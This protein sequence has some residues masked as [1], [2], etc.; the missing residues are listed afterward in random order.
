M[1]FSK[2]ECIQGVIVDVKDPEYL[3]R[4]KAVVPG[5]FDT[6]SMNKDALPWIYPFCMCGY[7]TFS[8]MVE[9]AKIWLLQNKDTHNEY[10]YLPYFEPIKM[11]ENYL[12]Q[13]YND[14]PEILFAR[15]NGNS[16]AMLTYDNI[17]GLMVTINDKTCYKFSPNGNIIISTTNSNNEKVGQSVIDG[18]C[19]SGNDTQEYQP[20]ILGNNLAEILYKLKDQFKQIA[21]ECG[22][23]TETKSLVGLFN[24]CANVIGDPQELLAKNS[25]CN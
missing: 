14:S 1:E 13:F 5:K 19:F 25:Y 3:G 7:Q 24:N 2:L 9:G 10:Y 20:I 23:G 16:S 18:K 17:N 15:N 22:A 21:L 8:K 4:I 6:A 11:V 12:H